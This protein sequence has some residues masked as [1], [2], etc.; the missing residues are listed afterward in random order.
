MI[1]T[2]TSSLPPVR[3]PV[4][5]FVLIRSFFGQSTHEVIG[6]WPLQ[7]PARPEV[8]DY[9]TEM[10]EWQRESDAPTDG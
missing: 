1:S 9:F 3:W 8:P 5:E 7:M 4:S 2:S 6:R 10:E